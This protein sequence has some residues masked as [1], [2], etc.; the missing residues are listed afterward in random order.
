MVFERIINHR[1]GV[2]R[3]CFLMVLLLVSLIPVRAQTVI[4]T[5]GLMNVA[6]ADMRPAGTFDGG[7]SF[8]QGGLLFDTYSSSKKTKEVPNRNTFIYY[9]SFTPF[10]WMELAFRETLLKYRNSSSDYVYRVDR[11]FSVRIQPLKE[12]K[13]WPAVVVGTN[14]FANTGGG[15]SAY[16]CIYGVATKHF[17][18]QHIGTFEATLG[19]TNP[20]KKGKTY[21]GV[22]GGLS[23][24]PEFFPDMRV[25]G[26]YDTRGFN[27]GVGAFLFK[28]LNVTCFTREFKGFNATVSYQYTIH[29]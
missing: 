19:Y 17:P 12:G 24:A 1:L 7:V 13:Y 21:D 16:A 4:G 15:I 28:H 29:Y 9:V 23:F 2:M 3:Q 10:S 11:S 26:E 18:L 20:I 5:N 25:M 8:I 14:D 27:I 6:T 22:M